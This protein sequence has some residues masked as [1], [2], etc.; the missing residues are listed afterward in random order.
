[1]RDQVLGEL[2]GLDACKPVLMLLSKI[3]WMQ[4]SYNMHIKWALYFH[5]L[6]LAIRI[7]CN[8]CAFHVISYVD[9][10]FFQLSKVS[11]F[12]GRE[13]KTDK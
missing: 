12:P 11:K 2:L 8:H 6:R 1:M 10:V 4:W 9:F 3:Y 7:S 13:K 5:Q